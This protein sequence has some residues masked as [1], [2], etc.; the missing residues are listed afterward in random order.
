MNFVFG[1]VGT[2]R[3]EIMLEALIP[4]AKEFHLALPDFAEP[5]ALAEL[6]AF[7]DKKRI[8]STCYLDDAALIKALEN[9]PSERIVCCGSM[10]LTGRL[11]R[12]FG[13]T[14]KSRWHRAGPA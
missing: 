5:V 12:A 14:M 4:Y 10:Y 9:S 2:K 11:R 7:L 1:V 13:L 8:K 3:W 6:S